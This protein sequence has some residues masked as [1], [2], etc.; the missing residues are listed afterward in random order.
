[1]EEVSPKSRL[2]TTLFAWFL[3][4]FGAHRF[5]LGKIGT[6]ILMLITLGGLGIWALIDFIMVVA[7]IMKDKEGR[8]IKNW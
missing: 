5:Y 6:A 4:E 8:P 7:G 2:A 1:M 3:G